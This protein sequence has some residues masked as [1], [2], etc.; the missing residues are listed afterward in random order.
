M[1]WAYHLDP[2]LSYYVGGYFW[3]Y[4]RQDV[5]TGKKRLADS[6]VSALR[7]RRARCRHT[8]RRLSPGR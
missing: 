4:G 7:A 5:F 6:L 3:W 8:V 1:S 2:G